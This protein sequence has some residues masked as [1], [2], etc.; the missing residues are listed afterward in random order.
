[1]D[2][3]KASK[4]FVSALLLFFCVFLIAIRLQLFSVY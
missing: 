3:K 1:M 4:K 2:F